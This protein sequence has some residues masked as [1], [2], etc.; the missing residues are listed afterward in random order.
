[1]NG[2]PMMRKETGTVS[3]LPPRT[4]TSSTR[5]RRSA[6]I[7]A[8]VERFAEQVPL[9]PL[10]RHLLGLIVDETIEDVSPRAAPIAVGK[11]SN[12]DGDSVG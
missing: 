9:T 12:D 6:A 3:P 7:L 8:A 4:V 2:E 10:Q 1:M 5:Q 11:A